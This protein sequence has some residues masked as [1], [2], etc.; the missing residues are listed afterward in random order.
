MQVETT[1]TPQARVNVID[2]RRT[3]DGKLVYLKK[4]RPDSQELEI[5]RYISSPEL[6]QH[7]QNHCVPLLDVIYDPS[8]PETCFVVMPYLR[9]IDHPPFELVEDMMEF[10]EVILEVSSFVLV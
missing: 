2:A 1:N 9:Y 7:P 4:I 10:G 8:D 6:V 5:L 3:S